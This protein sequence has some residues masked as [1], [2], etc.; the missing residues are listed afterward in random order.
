MGTNI[1]R[2]VA[3]RDITLRVTQDA[4]DKM[5][6]LGADSDEDYAD[7]LSDL[8]KLFEYLGAQL[9]HDIYKDDPDSTVRDHMAMVLRQATEDANEALQSLRQF[10][11][12]TSNTD[13]L[14]E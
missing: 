4:I 8:G 5:Q 11:I 13:E 2:I 7:A 12:T 6:A 3:V 1:S 14:G 10:D 9:L